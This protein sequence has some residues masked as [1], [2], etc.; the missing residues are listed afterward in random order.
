[1]LIEHW[2]LSGGMC[3][4]GILVVWG[5]SAFTFFYNKRLPDGNEEK[6]E[7]HPYSWLVAPLLLPFKVPILAL[8]AVLSF[9]FYSL[10][11]GLLLIVFALAVA[12]L[13]KPF[14]LQWL[15][16]TSLKVGRFILKINT[17]LLNWVWP[18][19]APRQA[20]A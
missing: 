15:K 2:Q 5:M 13:R 12:L 3:C 19:P 8:F 11:F 14:L 4:L 17:R 1:M 6:R 9:L 20:L 7:Y 18:M 10:V 16:E